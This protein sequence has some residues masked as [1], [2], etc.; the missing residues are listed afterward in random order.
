MYDFRGKIIHETSV[1]RGPL[2]VINQVTAS[3]T[4]CAA[5][6]YSD[7]KFAN[8]LESNVTVTLSGIKNPNNKYGDIKSKKGKQVESNTLSK[9]WN[10]IIG[11]A[12]RTMQKN[13]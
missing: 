1:A 5:D 6:I 2:M 13:T 7:E 10:I 3:T 4:F 12:K 8:I 9:H 11:K